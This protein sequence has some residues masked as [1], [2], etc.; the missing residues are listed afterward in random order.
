MLRIRT[1]GSE[2]GGFCQDQE[3]YGMCLAAVDFFVARPSWPCLH[4]LEAC[5][6]S[7]TAYSVFW[8]NTYVL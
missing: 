3:G 8:L 2:H 1:S 4:G 5:A 7:V 6:T